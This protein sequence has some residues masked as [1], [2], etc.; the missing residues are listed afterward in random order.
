MDYFAIGQ[1]TPGIIALNVSTF[2]GNKRK[3]VTG[4]I[5]ATLGFITVPIALLVIIAMFLKN[6]ADYT[7]EE[8]FCWGKG[9]CMCSYFKCD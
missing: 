4:G 3:G 9:M 6:F 7:I 1:C 5:A 2:I 8:C